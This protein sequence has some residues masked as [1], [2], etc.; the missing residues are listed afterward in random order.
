MPIMRSSKCRRIDADK[1]NSNR[2]TTDNDN[3]EDEVDANEAAL[4]SDEC[5][6]LFAQFDSAIGTNIFWEFESIIKHDISIDFFLGALDDDVRYD[7][8]LFFRFIAFMHAVD[9][10]A[11]SW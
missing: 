8:S 2:E 5:D 1:K 4:P 6:A 10:F 7:T 3:D 9:V 11:V